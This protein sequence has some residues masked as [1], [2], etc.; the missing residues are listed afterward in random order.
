VR[1]LSITTIYP[2]FHPQLIIR[3]YEQYKLTRNTCNSLYRINVSNVY[4][5]HS[6]HIL[7]EKKNIDRDSV[8]RFSTTAKRCHSHRMQFFWRI[9][10]WGFIETSVQIWFLRFKVVRKKIFKDI[11]F[12]S[13]QTEHHGQSRNRNPALA[14]APIT[15][16]EESIRED[17]FTGTEN[18]HKGI[19]STSHYILYKNGCLVHTNNIVQCLLRK[20]TNKE[21]Y[22]NRIL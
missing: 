11:S 14:P 13:P 9:L 8:T 2:T 6:C 21:L 19:R 22:A 3:K 12:K 17:R 4:R 1:L 18:Q 16:K 7:T 5:T 15:L 20:S 10:K